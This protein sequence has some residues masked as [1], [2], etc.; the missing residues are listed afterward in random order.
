[1]AHFSDI[2][3]SSDDDRG[4][5]VG[6]KSGRKARLKECPGCSAMLGVAVKECVY[7]DYTFTSKSVLNQVVSFVLLLI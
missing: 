4:R 2:D 6:R 1:M 3:D 5:P 7:C